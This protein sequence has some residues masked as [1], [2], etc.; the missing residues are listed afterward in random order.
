LEDLAINL[1]EGRPDR[2]GLSQRLAHRLLKQIR[3]DCA[4]DPHE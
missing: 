3:L 1:K 2:F 4:L